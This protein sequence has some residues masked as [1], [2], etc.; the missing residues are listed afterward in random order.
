MPD[1]SYSRTSGP[2]LWVIERPR[3][4]KCQTRMSLAGIAPGPSG[5]DL[6]TFECGKCEHVLK[7]VISTDPMKVRQS[8]MVG[9]RIKSTGVRSAFEKTALDEGR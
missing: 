2:S 8:W 3:C 6:R 1:Y 4:P 5:Y 7:E 9:R